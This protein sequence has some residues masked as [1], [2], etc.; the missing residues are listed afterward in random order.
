M[1]ERYRKTIYCEMQFLRECLELYGDGTALDSS[2]EAVRIWKSLHDL[3]LSPDVNLRLDISTEDYLKEIKDIDKRRLK[4]AKK[5]E[6]LLLNKMETLLLDFERRRQGEADFHLRCLG[7]DFVTVDALNSGND[8]SLNAIYLTCKDA[9]TCKRVAASYGVLVFTSKDL[10]LERLSLG[11]EGCAI[12]KGESGGWLGK[13]QGH[14]CNAVAIVDNYI[15]SDTRKMDEN[16]TDILQA[17]LPHTLAQDMVFH[18]TVF[19]SDLKLQARDRLGGLEQMVKRLR[20]ELNCQ[21]SLFRCGTNV[22]HD[23]VIISNHQWFGCGG[24]FDLFKNKKSDKMTTVNIIV[25]YLTDTVKWA[26]R[27][28]ANLVTQLGEEINKKTAYINDSFPSFCLGAGL[29]RLIQ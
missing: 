21:V 28:Y 17:L 14:A 6:K 19:T 10:N 27:A 22:F 7:T 24:G 5:G 11:D 18:L 23:R 2:Q 26:R 25:P 1:T 4:A 20:P 9:E 12:A 8:L 13:L 16:M 15:M 29:N 3:L